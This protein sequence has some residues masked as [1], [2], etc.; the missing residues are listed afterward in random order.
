MAAR[1]LLI[2]LS[3][4][5]AAAVDAHHGRHVAAR[6]GR[7]GRA[8]QPADV[9]EQ[10]AEPGAAHHRHHRV[11]IPRKRQLLHRLDR[12]AREFQE[13]TSALRRQGNDAEVRRQAGLF[14]QHQVERFEDLVGEFGL[15]ERVTGA[16]LAVL[17]G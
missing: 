7:D 12:E 9:A 15:A 4:A 13:A 3:V 8:D 14:M 11:K 17:P 1:A 10:P 6:L 2:A 5:A 16:A